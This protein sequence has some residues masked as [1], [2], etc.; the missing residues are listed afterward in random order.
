MQ[1]TRLTLV[2][3]RTKPGA[4]DS[5]PIVAP[6]VGVAELWS[7]GWRVKEIPGVFLVRYRLENQ[8]AWVAIFHGVAFVNEELSRKA[9]AAVLRLSGQH[10]S[11]R[12]ELLQAV[13]ASWISVEASSA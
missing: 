3:S 8:T 12:R 6:G 9:E 4:K 2:K 7:A 5:I 11:T 10:F 13:E 1:S